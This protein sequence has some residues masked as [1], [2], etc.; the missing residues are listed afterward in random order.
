VLAHCFVL[1]HL[2]LR[3]IYRERGRYREQNRSGRRRRWLGAVLFDAEEKN[4]I[5][6]GQRVTKKRKR[7]KRL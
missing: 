7:R 2:Y 3:F 6:G 4:E 5:E 1:P